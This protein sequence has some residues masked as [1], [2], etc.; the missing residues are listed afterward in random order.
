MRVQQ[1][2]N[3]GVIEDNKPV[4]PNKWEEIKGGGEAAIERWID[5]NINRSSCVVVL[6]GS[7]TC[8]SRWVQYEIKKAWSDH[9]GLVGIYIHNLKDPNYG[10]CAKG[11]NPFEQV[12]LKNGKKL[13]DYIPVYDA[14]TDAYNW[15]DKNIEA[16]V[17][18]GIQSCRK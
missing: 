8:K 1:I 16:V 7:G 14:G 17:E 13:S 3:L 11:K 18:K 4:T 9:K 2:R 12:I 15:I 6:I 10:V 5:E